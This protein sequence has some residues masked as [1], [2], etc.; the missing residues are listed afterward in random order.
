MDYTYTNNIF[1]VK[2]TQDNELIK[3]L[4]ECE[5]YFF[6]WAEARGEH[7]LYLEIPSVFYGAVKNRLKPFLIEME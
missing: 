5:Y 2:N 7:D 3:Q 1:K 4:E 6:V